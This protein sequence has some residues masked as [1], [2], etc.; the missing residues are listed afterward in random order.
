MNAGSK[1][2]WRMK[3]QLM[4]VTEELICFML[5]K[6]QSSGWI[7][8]LQSTYCKSFESI[9][10]FFWKLSAELSHPWIISSRI[11]SFSRHRTGGDQ[12]KVDVGFTNNTLEWF[13]CFDLNKMCHIWQWNHRK[14]CLITDI[15]MSL[16]AFWLLKKESQFDKYFYWQWELWWYL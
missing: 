16:L 2:N 10:D 9:P 7:L 8:S 3:G 14:A 11:L 6:E 13:Y 12:Y 1:N 4:F 15:G 5:L